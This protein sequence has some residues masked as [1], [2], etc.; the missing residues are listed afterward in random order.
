MNGLL[1]NRKKMFRYFLLLLVGLT[2]T[3]NGLIGYYYDT[4]KFKNAITDEEV[5]ERA[6]ALG[7]VEI[8]E[9]IEGETDGQ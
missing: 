6:K 4:A 8:K 5:I 9:Q 1:F 7:Y 3:V 2:L